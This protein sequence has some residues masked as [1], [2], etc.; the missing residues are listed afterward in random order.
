MKAILCWQGGKRSLV[1]ELLRRCPPHRVYIEPFFGAG[2]MFWAKDP[3]EIEV[4]NDIDPQLMAFYR[5]F[6]QKRRFDCDMTPSRERW[7]K[8]KARRQ[9]G[10]VVPAC[11]FLFQIKYA[12]RCDGGKSYSPGE[13]EMC[14]RSDNPKLCQ[15]S[16]VAARFPDYKSR[17]ARTKIMNSDWRKVVSEFDCKDGFIFCD[18]PYLETDCNY[19][20]CEI[21]PQEMANFLSGLKCRWLVTLNDHPMVRKAFKGRRIEVVTAVY[22]TGRGSKTVPNLIIRNYEGFYDGN[23]N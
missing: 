11:D 23:H 19:H 15:V 13:A 20:S 1:K 4:I 14:A 6:V 9:S 22:S 3:A 2:H 18:P 7:D 21:N 16:E 12:F 8:I 17:L 5:E 10:D